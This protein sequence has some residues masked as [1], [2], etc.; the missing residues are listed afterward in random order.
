MKHY[1]LAL[2]IAVLTV[3]GCIFGNKQEDLTI[4]VE[5]IETA[6]PAF[7]RIVVAGPGKVFSSESP[8]DPKQLFIRA[9]IPCVKA[10][11]VKLAGISMTVDIL[12]VNGSV[13]LQGLYAEGLPDII[14]VLEAGEGVSRTIIFASEIALDKA[15]VK[16]AMEKTA[17]LRINVFGLP[18]VDVAAQDSAAPGGPA[19][20]PTL[21]TLIRKY[22]AWYLLSEYEKGVRDDN[23]HIRKAAEHRIEA[24]KDR[25]DKEYP[26]W[27]ADQ[28]DDWI[29]DRMDRIDD[30]Y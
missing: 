6:G 28:F 30:K 14:P 2:S 5:A 9:S 8:L 24:A 27:L 17:R 4:P 29:E 20:P 15:S 25:A 1:L 26:D 22:N 11:G 23:K 3:T 7:N 18:G 19:G 21:N 12:D 10:I 13:V 16:R